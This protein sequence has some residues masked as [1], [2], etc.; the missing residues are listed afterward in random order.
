MFVQHHVPLERLALEA[1][2][3]FAKWFSTIVATSLA[4]GNAS[5]NIR[6]DRW[7]AQC[8]RLSKRDCQGNPTKK[9]KINGVICT[10]PKQIVST[11]DVVELDGVVVASLPSMLAFHKPKGMITSNS[12]TQGR[13]CVGDHLHVIILLVA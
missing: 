4:S 12:D 10:I 13:L 6:L 3:G 5:M 1:S 9:V 11:I 2:I 7:I 8:G